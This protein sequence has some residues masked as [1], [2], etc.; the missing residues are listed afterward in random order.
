MDQ[1]FTYVQRKHRESEARDFPGRH[2][3]R[4]CVESESDMNYSTPQNISSFTK[5]RHITFHERTVAS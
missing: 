5:T 3:Q 4:G 2:R 1:K